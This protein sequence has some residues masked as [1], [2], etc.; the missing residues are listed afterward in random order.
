MA[1]ECRAQTAES[2]DLS[3]GCTVEPL[4]LLDPCMR[5]TITMIIAG[6]SLAYFWRVRAMY[7]PAW[8]LT[9]NSEQVS[10][11]RLRVETT[12]TPEK[13]VFVHG[14]RRLL[15]VTR[16]ARSSFVI[17]IGLQNWGAAVKT[18]STHTHTHCTDA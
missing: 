16:R 15:H 5:I 13:H 11:L 10:I 4:K 7:R 9:G 12:L 18:I 3:L 6:L 2:L 8:P 17:L 1:L 14:N